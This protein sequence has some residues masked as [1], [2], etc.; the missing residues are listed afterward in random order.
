MI[1]IKTVGWYSNT[2]PDSP[3]YTLN[4]SPP[5]ALPMKY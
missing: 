2:Y 1:E 3:F 4:I 5:A